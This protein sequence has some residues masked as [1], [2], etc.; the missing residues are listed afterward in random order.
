MVAPVSGSRVFDDMVSTGP[1]GERWVFGYGSLMWRP[2]FDFVEASA[3]LLHGR[4][5]A[6]CIYSVHHRGTYERPGLVLGLAPGGAV[7]GRAYRVA[8]DQWPNVYAYLCEREQP[9][10][11]YIESKA[12]ISLP[13]GQ[14]VQAMVF[15]SDLKH[16]QWAGDLSLEAQA[17]LIA[18]AA[19]LSGRNLDYLT[20]LVEHLRAEGI[21][22]GHLEALLVR[23]QALEAAG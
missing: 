1:D 5:R 19:G 23:V 22:D 13:N 21:R 7:R 12:V 6:F 8:K 14:R 9:T 20:D 16:P 18:G 17:G 15:L 10:E 4:R 3:A 2:G 11:T